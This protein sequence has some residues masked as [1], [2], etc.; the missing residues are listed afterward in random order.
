M[1]KHKE[2][3][4]NERNKQRKKNIRGKQNKTCGQIKS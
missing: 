3:S 1:H 4:N 2:D